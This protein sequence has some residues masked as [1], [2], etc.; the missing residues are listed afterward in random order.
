MRRCQRLPDVTHPVDSTRPV[1]GH[2]KS[3]AL[4][5]RAKS[6]Q[7]GTGKSS[8]N[9][10]RPRMET[11]ADLDSERFCGSLLTSLRS[12]FVFDEIGIDRMVT[13]A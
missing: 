8:I 3:R 5:R 6:L 10:P 4:R 9:V 12:P 11:A 1:E 7:N 2:I 13:N